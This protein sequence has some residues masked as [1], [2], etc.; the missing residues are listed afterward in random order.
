MEEELFLLVTDAIFSLEERLWIKNYAVREASSFKDLV[1]QKNYFSLDQLDSTYY[2]ELRSKIGVGNSKFSFRS[3]RI[4]R[5]LEKRLV[6]KDEHVF[7]RFH[8]S[9]LTRDTTFS[10]KSDEMIAKHLHSIYKT[11]TNDR[12]LFDKQQLELFRGGNETPIREK[13]YEE[14]FGSSLQKLFQE[15]KTPREYGGSISSN[16][17]NSSNSSSSRV[18]S[19][20][21]TGSSGKPPHQG[22]G[23]GGRGGGG[24]SGGGISLSRIEGGGDDLESK[25]DDDRLQ[26]ESKPLKRRQRVEESPTTTLTSR[27]QRIRQIQEL[28]KVQPQS[29]NAQLY[30][31][32]NTVLL[33]PDQQRT[34]EVLNQ[35]RYTNCSFQ[36]VE[37]F[38]NSLGYHRVRQ[39]GSHVILEEETSGWS[40]SVPNSNPVAPGTLRNILTNERYGLG[41]DI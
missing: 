30:R 18:T 14:D 10:G 5:G 22:G 29:T 11:A 4:F 20:T 39:T 41:M 12:R 13:E 34:F 8:L 25:L 16:S 28:N 36:E 23:G 32:R 35:K 21:E 9:F 40:V 27:Q 1:L 2:G 6:F 7:R 19:I 31:N 3:S 15:K 26:R 33:T 17:S 38:L 24:Q 37:R